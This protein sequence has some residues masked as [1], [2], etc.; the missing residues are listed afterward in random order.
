M[1]SLALHGVG[2]L[3]LEDRPVPVAGPGQVLVRVAY[4]G[5]CG[6]DIPRIFE[7]GTYHFPTV[8]GHEFSGIVADTGTGVD[9]VRRGDRVVVFP[10]LWCGRCP[11]CEQGRYVQCSDYDYLGSRSDGGFS[12]YIVAPEANVVPVPDQVRLIDAAMT[13]PAAV[14]LHAL[15]RADTQ[16]IGKTVVIMGAGPIGLLVAQCAMVG[17]AARIALFD[18]SHE[19]LA[20]ARSLGL[21]D[22]HDP[23]ADS[24]TTV[25]PEG[26]AIV[27]DATGVPAALAQ[28]LEALGDGGTGVLLGNPAGDLRL[29]AALWSRL[30]RR[31]AQL[32]GTWN[33]AY[34]RYSGGDDWRTVLGLMA[35]GALRT[36]P[37]IT[38]CVP[39]EEAERELRSIY[40][41]SGYHCKTMIELSASETL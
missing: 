36:G 16:L 37:L 1:R 21:A 29:P 40:D 15:G 14:A 38:H 25:V 7:K 34:S 5:I 6:S 24:P 23:R 8:P 18:V 32:V 26:A 4:C 2:D 20:T 31:E 12:D 35:L 39:L 22:V 3:R 33:S 28:G 19:A 10:L 13:E 41:R 27:V 17:G 9:L 11:A 30:M